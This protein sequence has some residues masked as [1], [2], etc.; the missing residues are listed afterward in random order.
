[1]RKL[2]SEPINVEI[3][4]I[5]LPL[6]NPK[7][8]VEGASVVRAVLAPSTLA[9]KNPAQRSSPIAFCAGFFLFDARLRRAPPGARNAIA[10]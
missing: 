1:M 7:K 3:A 5:C 2:V 4:K 9:E 8:S 10:Q 6:S